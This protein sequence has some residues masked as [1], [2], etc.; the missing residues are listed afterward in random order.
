MGKVAYK[1]KGTNSHL[2]KNILLG[3]LAETITQVHMWMES[4]PV[5]QFSLTLLLKFIK[6]KPVL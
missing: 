4:L 1:Q 2:L 5:L 3:N 6:P